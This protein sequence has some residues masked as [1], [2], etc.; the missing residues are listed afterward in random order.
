MEAGNQ[1]RLNGEPSP[2]LSRLNGDSSCNSNSIGVAAE[3][4][5]DST[6][7]ADTAHRQQMVPAVVQAPPASVMSLPR[8]GSIRGA[9]RSAFD[10]QGLPVGIDFRQWLGHFEVNVV[11]I[12]FPLLNPA[13]HLDTLVASSP[14]LG[15][16]IEFVTSRLGDAARASRSANCCLLSLKATD[17]LFMP[18]SMIWIGGQVKVNSRVTPYRAAQGLTG[19]NTQTRRGSA[20]RNSS[21]TARLLE[22]R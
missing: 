2:G 3:P 13:S 20:P 1:L 12:H 4:P 8:T 9:W 16:G 19:L 22:K 6:R 10:L 15:P 14:S 5:R 7:D 18:N 21:L 11:Q 17:G